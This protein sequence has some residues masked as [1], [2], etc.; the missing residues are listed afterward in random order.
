MK[1]G[2]MQPYFLPYI[3]Y[4]QLIKAVDTFV[5]YDNIKYTKKGW[6]NRNRYLQNGTDAYFTLP[7]KKDSDFLD[8]KDRYIAD[9]FDKNKI[10][11]QIKAAYEKAPYY[12]S[13]FQLFKTLIEH[14]ALNLFEYIYFSVNHVCAYLSINT[15]I[16]KSSEIMI[17]H[18]LKSEEKVIEICKWLKADTYINPIGG[19]K[20]YSKEHFKQ[21]R[22]NLNF[23]QSNE[24]QY[25]QYDNDFVPWLSILDVMMFNTL[26]QINQMLDK[27]ELILPQ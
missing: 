3:G 22:I 23:I 6:I 2:I 1:L 21:N 12:N 9:S 16:I 17:E 10:L 13:A 20:L 4:W 7:L 14:D 11:N 19:Q 18:S 27:Y 26:E 5:I 15:K 24:I 8:V 25:K